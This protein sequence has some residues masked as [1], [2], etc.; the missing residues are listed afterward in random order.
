MLSSRFLS[1]HLVQ[2]LFCISLTLPQCFCLSAGVA[3]PGT[4]RCLA[5]L[6]PTA[7]DPPTPRYLRN[8]DVNDKFVL[9]RGLIQSTWC[10]IVIAMPFAILQPNTRYA[11]MGNACRMFAG[12]TVGVAVLGTG[13]HIFQGTVSAVLGLP[14]CWEAAAQPLAAVSAHISTGFLASALFHGPFSL[15]P[16]A[17]SIG[18]SFP[19]SS[20]MNLCLLGMYSQHL[21]TRIRANNV[22]TDQERDS[23]RE[24]EPCGSTGEGGPTARIGVVGSDEASCTCLVS[25][26]PVRNRL[27]RRFGP[28][29]GAYGLLV[30]TSCRKKVCLEIEPKHIGLHIGP[31]HTYIACIF[32]FCLLS[33]GYQ[34][35]QHLQLA[36]RHRRLQH[37]RRM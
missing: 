36:G 14:E 12:A 31:V 4:T 25:D 34:Q 1:F 29:K 26:E 32:L 24:S 13:Q 19:G 20:L 10:S 3:S 23:G 15:A 33:S 21:P 2:L 30:G 35:P 8:A 22:K 11:F 7:A 37:L 5:H 9:M 27:V 28:T 16:L 18:Q 6:P 17:G